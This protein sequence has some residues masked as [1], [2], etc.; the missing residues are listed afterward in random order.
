M[1]ETDCPQSHWKLSGVLFNPVEVPY[2]SSFSL[3]RL[4]YCVSNKNDYW[5][6]CP[7]LGQSDLI[8]YFI[9][10]FSNFSFKI[11]NYFKHDLLFKYNRLKRFVLLRWEAG[12]TDYSPSLF[13]PQHRFAYSR[14]IRL[15]HRL[16]VPPMDRLPE[17]NRLKGNCSETCTSLYKIRLS[18]IREEAPA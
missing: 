1:I 14:K 11:K 12:Q 3:C 5:C 15:T 10:Y 17:N 13:A 16:I 7:Q 2:Q 9:L 18:R 6:W 4:R 8:V